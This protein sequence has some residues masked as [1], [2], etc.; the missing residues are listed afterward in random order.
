VVWLLPL[1]RSND[2]P[3]LWRQGSAK[4]AEALLESLQTPLSPIETA[5]AQE[6]KGHLAAVKRSKMQACRIGLFVQAKG[7]AR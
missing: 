6:N 7:L 5:W 4:L 3:G 2:K 1:K